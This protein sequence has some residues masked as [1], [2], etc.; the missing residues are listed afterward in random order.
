MRGTVFDLPP[1][2]EVTGVRS[3]GKPHGSMGKVH[4]IRPHSVAPVAPV[5]HLVD[6][7]TGPD[8]S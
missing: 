5:A 8:A 2:I 4:E 3:A 7:F 1:V 6:R